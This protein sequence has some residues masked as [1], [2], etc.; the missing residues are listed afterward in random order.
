V[1]QLEKHI[2]NTYIKVSRSKHDKPYKYRKNFDAFEDNKNY[3][4][5][6][7][8]HRFFKKFPHIKIEDFF[9]CPYEVYSD[10][11]TYDLRFYTT[12]KAVK[13]YG[14]YTTQRDNECPDSD[15]QIKFI[16]DSLMHI[17]TFCRQHHIPISQYMNHMTNNIHT[18]IM[19]IRERKVSFYTLFGFDNFNSILSSY[20][21]SQIQFTL[22]KN[23]EN[24]LALYKTRYYNSRRAKTA[25]QSGLAKIDKLLY[26]L[27]NTSK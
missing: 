20:P 16:T 18:F 4:Y 23:I 6:K 19:H 15:Y 17:F 12:P 26:K 13:M 27:K 7:K 9:N 22:G 14:T 25:I 1:T 24:N 21:Q 8:L 3:I 5:V 11:D 10:T 2:Y